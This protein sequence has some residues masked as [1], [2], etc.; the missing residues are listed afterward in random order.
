MKY[1]ILALL[2]LTIY[3][4]NEA[5]SYNNLDDVVSVLKT[6]GV[7]CDDKK[8]KDFKFI[9]AS[10][11]FYQCGVEMYQFSS[12]KGVDGAKKMLASFG[13]KNS[14]YFVVGDKILVAQT[15]GDTS[16]KLFNKIKGVLE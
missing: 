12:N 5:K 8:S 14:Q 7:S 16:T 11:G 6:N 9:K 4:C 15:M 3:S 1:L 13:I 10:N 2:S